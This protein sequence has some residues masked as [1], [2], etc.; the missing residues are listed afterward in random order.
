VNAEHTV[1]INKYSCSAH[2][3]LI[4]LALRQATG[5]PIGCIGS[6]TGHLLIV[7]ILNRS[8][9]SCSVGAP[10]ACCKSTAFRHI[11]VTFER[12]CGRQTLTSIAFAYPQSVLRGIATISDNGPI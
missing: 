5:V 1:L 4:T 2:V 9:Q 10:D 3:S 7:G 12:Q 8:D 6:A 11:A